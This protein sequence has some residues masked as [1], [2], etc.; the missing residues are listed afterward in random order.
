MVSPSQSTTTCTVSSSI[1]N[2]AQ[3][4]LLKYSSAN[5]SALTTS[6]PTAFNSQQLVWQSRLTANLTEPNYLMTPIYGTDSRF[7]FAKTSPSY[8]N[9]LKLAVENQKDRHLPAS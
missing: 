6:S 4:L 5:C 9:L 8:S 2:V 7:S 1:S 3:I